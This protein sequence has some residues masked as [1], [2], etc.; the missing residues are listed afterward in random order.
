[1][2]PFGFK[3]GDPNSAAVMLNH[4]HRLQTAA[5]DSCRLRV[6]AHLTVART[7]NPASFALKDDVAFCQGSTRPPLV[8][9]GRDANP[10]KAVA[11]IARPYLARLR[12]LRSV[13]GALGGLRSTAAALC[14]QLLCLRDDAIHGSRVCSQG[15]KG[16]SRCLIQVSSMF[17]RDFLKPV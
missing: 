8:R 6:E 1:M 5:E 4:V 12:H 14:F 9:F 10:L 3:S 13:G 11:N 2:V 15:D 7:I 16:L 17:C